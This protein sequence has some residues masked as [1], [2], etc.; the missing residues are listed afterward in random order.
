ML[1]AVDN[2]MNS[3]AEVRYTQRMT[4][5]PRHKPLNRTA[6]ALLGIGALTFTVVFVWDMVRDRPVSH[7]SVEIDR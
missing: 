6:D 1:H 5:K 4:K 2:S 3:E 7:G